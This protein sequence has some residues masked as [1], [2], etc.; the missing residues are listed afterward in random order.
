MTS[1]FMNVLLVFYE[2]LFANNIG[3][4]SVI[5]HRHA[6]ANS[7]M[8]STYDLTKPESYLLYIDANVSRLS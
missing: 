4:I 5:S 6:E 7:P 2:F 8:L 1:N 3:G